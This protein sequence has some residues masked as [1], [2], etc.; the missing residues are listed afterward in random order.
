MGE[1]EIRFK[2]RTI[3]DLFLFAYRGL[4]IKSGLGSMYVLHAMSNLELV[5]GE[6]F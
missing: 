1:G 4:S 2:N 5:K 6:R 3:R